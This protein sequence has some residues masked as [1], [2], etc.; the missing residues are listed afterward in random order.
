MDCTDIQKN[1]KW[2]RFRW[3]HSL[4]QDF[5]AAKINATKTEETIDYRNENDANFEPLRQY[6][7]QMMILGKECMFREIF[8]WR[9][10][11]KSRE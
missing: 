11:F 8:G 10:I 5:D 4:D 6:R 3:R 2:L 7:C 9:H 1:M